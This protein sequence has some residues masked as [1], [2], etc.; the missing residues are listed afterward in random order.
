MDIKIKKRLLCAILFSI[1][2]T[3]FLLLRVDW[4]HFSLIAGRLDI[5][6]LIAAY[7][8]FLF[9]NL[10]RTFRFYKLDHMDKKLSD[11][12][13]INVFYNFIT[14]TLPGGSGEAATAYVLKRFSKFNIL[15]A[16]RILLLSRLMD[17]FA[18]SSLFFIAALMMRS[19]TSYREAAIWLSGTLL[20]ISSV[21]LLRS[22]GQV[23][24]KLL[25]CLPGHSALM[26]RVN[27]KLS[28]LL[29]I[30]EEQRGNN[31]FGITLFQSALMWI[32]GIV[33]MHLVLRSFGIDFTLIQSAYCFGVYAIFQIVPVQGIAGIGTQAAWWALALNAAGY[34]GSEAIALGFVLHGTYYLFISSMG[35]FSVLVWLKGRGKR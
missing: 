22:S 18:L 16:L 32:G 31:S 11:W 29:N 14:A 25:L 10:I 33:L 7:C 24:M 15:G 28:E 35:I 21:S 9:G 5:K 1:G 12:W 30:S 23:V 6:E 26:K 3:I 17:L 8:V 19:D 2:F 34:S 4:S 13:Y 20:L 27:E